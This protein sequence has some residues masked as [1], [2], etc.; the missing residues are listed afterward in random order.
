M[1]TK[2]FV[3]MTGLDTMTQEEREA[4]YKAACE[5]LGLRDDQ[6]L[7]EYIWLDDGNMGRHLVLYIKSGATDSLREF[8]G[9]SVVEMKECFGDGFVSFIAKG[10]KGNRTDI[11]VGSATTKGL[12]GRALENAIMTA[13]TRASRR[14]TLQLTGGGLLDETEVKTPSELAKANLLTTP[15]GSIHTAPAVQEN[16]SIGKDIT[17]SPIICEHANEVPA[18]CTCSCELCIKNPLCQDSKLKQRDAVTRASNEVVRKAIEDV[19]VDP[20]AEGKKRRK[21]RTVQLEEPKA[22]A[23]VFDAGGPPNITPSPAQLA[24][25]EA[26][27]RSLPKLV[28]ESPED[29]EIR[30]AEERIAALKAKKAAAATPEPI[31]TPQP[32]TVVVPSSAAVPTLVQATEPPPPTSKPKKD[33]P[34][35]EQKEAFQTRRFKYTNEILKNAGMKNCEGIGGISFKLRNLVRIMFPGVLEEGGFTVSQ[36]NIFL[37]YLDENLQQLG[38]EGLVKLINQKIGA[39]E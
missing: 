17:A 7:L 39:K 2:K 15:V 31:A 29:K 35:P 34:T 20:P 13:Q 1:T 6:N 23:P 16:A 8:H 33:M 18:V 9:I 25:R 24:A 37:G 22:D 19:I 5:Y 38:P 32:V 3:P 36:W 27:E 14:L 11:A 26:L 10:V 12:V 4:Y 30:E 28:Q 21:R